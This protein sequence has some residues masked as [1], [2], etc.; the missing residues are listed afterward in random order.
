LLSQ[1][2][3]APGE[4]SRKAADNDPDDDFT[5]VHSFDAML[6]THFCDLDLLKGRAPGSLETVVAG[7]SASEV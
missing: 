7:A 3:R 4:R 6:D 5:D 2:D 1:C